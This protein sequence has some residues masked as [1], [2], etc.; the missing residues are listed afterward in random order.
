MSMSIGWIGEGSPH[1]YSLE[2]LMFTCFLNGI[3][4]RFSKV[5]DGGSIGEEIWDGMDG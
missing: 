1:S 4:F 5:G 2:V 3:D